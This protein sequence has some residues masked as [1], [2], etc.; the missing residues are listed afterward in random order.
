EAEQRRAE[1]TQRGDYE[2][3]L[4]YHMPYLE[5]APLVFTS[6]VTGEGLEA[7]LKTAIDVAAQFSRR[8]STGELNRVVQ[9][10]MQQHQPPARGLRALK[11]Y[12]ATQVDTR[13]PTFVLKCNDPELCHFSYE[14]YLR[15]KLRE[16][17]GLTGVPIRLRLEG[18]GGRER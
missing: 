18:R 9:R 1:K 14:R 2:R 12:Y 8:I 7:L 5:Y 15:N 13:P 10:A 11:V 3:I 16:E 6:A 4:R 17:F